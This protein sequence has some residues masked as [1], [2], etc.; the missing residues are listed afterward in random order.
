[1]QHLNQKPANRTL[2]DCQQAEELAAST[3]E[4]RPLTVMFCDL[5]DSTELSTK[6]DPEDLQDVIRA[7]Q[8][9]LCKAGQRT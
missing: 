4:R 9:V 1:M 6:L 8:N 5:A 7:Y 2:P 3:S